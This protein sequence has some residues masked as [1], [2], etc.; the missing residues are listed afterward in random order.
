MLTLRL[1]C[2]LF[3][4]RQGLADVVTPTTESPNRINGGQRVNETVPFQVSLQMQRRGRWQHFCGGSIVSGQHVL[5]AAHCMEKM[6]VE[7]VSVVV[8]TLNWKAGGLRHRV[9]TKHV[10]PQY[11]ISPRIINDIALVKVTPP[12]RLQRS[13]VSTILIG[14]SDRIGEKV[15]VR[16]TGWGSTTSSTSSATLPDQ[17][18]ALNYRTISNEDCNQ[19]GF[20]VTR[21][22][23]CALAVQ[24]QG[25][26]VGDSGG[27]LIKPGL[28]PHLV[29]I[30]S[31]GSS[32][33]AQGRP[34]VYTR[35]SSFLPYISQVINQDLAQ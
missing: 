5:T 6:K 7:D 9:V 27:P 16:L 32:T 14:G 8:G 28:Q 18:Q 31:Y 1:F 15:P 34:D 24:G 22:E 4:L 12:F 10:H 2:M 21:N 19:K 23:I 25:A 11:S 3:I 29:G 33:C 13:D 17:L 26:C 20:R 35:V 30:V